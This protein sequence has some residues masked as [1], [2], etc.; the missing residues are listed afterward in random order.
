MR[1]STTAR[2]RTGPRELPIPTCRPSRQAC[3]PRRRTAICSPRSNCTPPCALTWYAEP[4]ACAS[5]SS[6]RSVAASATRSLTPCDMPRLIID[7]ARPP[8]NRHG[9]P[10][11]IADTRPRP[12][13]PRIRRSRSRPSR[14]WPP[15][16]VVIS[17][18]VRPLLPRVGG[19]ERRANGDVRVRD[20]RE[21][22]EIRQLLVRATLAGQRLERDGG[23]LIHAGAAADLRRALARQPGRVEPRRRGIV[24]ARDVRRSLEPAVGTDRRAVVVADHHVRRRRGDQVGLL[25]RRLRRHAATCDRQDDDRTRACGRRPTHASALHRVR[26][27][28]QPAVTPHQTLGRCLTRTAMCEAAL[29]RKSADSEPYRTVVVHG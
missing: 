6:V 18:G 15:G 1:L 14:C 24:D 22:D 16:T 4:D 23:A 9:P 12:R 27:R 5:T 11:V 13:A 10:P 3:A 28:S 19:Q 2:R 21:A 17:L 25:G 26:G 20:E 7:S 29:V 8:P